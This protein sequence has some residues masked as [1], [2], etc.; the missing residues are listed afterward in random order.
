[1]NVQ[2][3]A[4]ALSCK[5]HAR[6]ARTVTACV[7]EVSSATVPPEAVYWFSFVTSPK[8]TVR[9]GIA[10]RTTCCTVVD[11]VAV[12]GHEAL[13]APFAE[14]VWADAVVAV[15]AKAATAATGRNFLNIAIRPH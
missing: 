12:T 1:V 14:Q 11:T 4:V 13:A 8:A 9:L 7:A 10:K 3:V 15:R 5:R 2:F 6:F